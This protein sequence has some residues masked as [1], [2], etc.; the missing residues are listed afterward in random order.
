MSVAPGWYVDPADPETRRYWDGEGWI[1][2]PIPVDATP[3]EGPPPPEPPAAEP[4]P[5]PVSPAAGQPP[6]GPAPATPGG[7]TAA[8]PA[9]AP[10][11]GWPPHAAPPHG[12]GPPPGWPYPTWPGRPPEPRPHGL[13][14]AGYGA[15][16]TAR[17]IDF[18]VVFALNAAV[19]SFFV[20]RLVQEFRPTYAEWWRRVQNGEMTSDP[21]PQ[22]GAQAESLLIVILLIATALWL[23]YE[24]PAM[25]A[26]GQTFGKRVMGI[27]AVPLA[28]DQPLGMG[29]A[30][31]RWNTL[32]L[33]TLL[34]YCCGLGLL[35]QLFDAISPLF[36]HPLRQALHDKR[37]Q[38]VVVQVPRE[39]RTPAP[40]DRTTPPGD[41]P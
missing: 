30:L 6:A 18:A 16:L 11:G 10:P 2:A 4:P 14:L 9:A 31:R 41:T 35:L 34:W 40:K 19:N 20:W 25:A 28:A 24:V 7:P 21:L 15:R 33:P 22:P 36:D 3:P 13:P 38:T 17:L 32:G 8:P 12:Y 26:G 1:G 39:P 5:A 29:R 23:A 37:A 27:K